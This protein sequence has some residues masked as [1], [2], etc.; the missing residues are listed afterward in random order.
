ME[1]GPVKTSEL[2]SSVNLVFSGDAQADT[3]Y[4]SSQTASVT[5]PAGSQ[6]AS[7]TLTGID[8]SE[9]ES[10]ETVSIALALQ[11]D[12]EGN[13]ISNVELSSD[14][15][16]DVQIS[17]DEAPVVSFATSETQI[18]ENAGSTVVTATLSNAKLEPTTVSLSLE[19]SATLLED[20]NVSAIYG[21][22]NFAG[23]LY[24]FG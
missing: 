5:I 18:P 1:F 22:S 17:D 2:P 14:V 7:F 9:D 12:E 19:G 8:D 23:Q 21:Y 4:S 10:I 24:N 3:D 16:L 11:T 15:S 20:Y 6:S 13:S